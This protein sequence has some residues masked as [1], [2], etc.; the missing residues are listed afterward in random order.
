MLS[1][2]SHACGKDEASR[3]DCGGQVGWRG[4]LVPLGQ[5]AMNAGL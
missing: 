5:R 3:T 1:R 4:G 2:G